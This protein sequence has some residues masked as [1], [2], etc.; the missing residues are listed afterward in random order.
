MLLGKKASATISLLAV[1]ATLTACGGSSSS[2]GTSP[3]A[4]VKAICNAVG[5]FE[6]D[7][8]TR[9]SSLDLSSI[10]SAQQGKTALQGF[11]TAVA[12]DTDQAVT[13]LKAAGT[14]SI[15]NGKQIQAAIV[16]AFSQLKTALQQ[17]A[18]SAGSL[19]TSSP[20]AFKIAAQALGKSVQTSMSSIGGSLSGLKSA[21]LESAA[22]KEAACQ[23]LGA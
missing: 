12:S 22:K 4:Y 11:L 21:A 15:N 2:S 5:P 23:S 19:P 6:K 8:Q 18:T 7:V 14:P 13:K 17:A 16:S 1:S 3:Q 20:T 10:K 9:S